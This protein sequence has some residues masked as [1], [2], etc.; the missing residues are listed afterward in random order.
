MGGL[1]LQRGL[2]RVCCPLSSFAVSLSTQI[3]HQEGDAMAGGDNSRM[4]LAEVKSFPP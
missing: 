4:S 2:G 1:G 3:S